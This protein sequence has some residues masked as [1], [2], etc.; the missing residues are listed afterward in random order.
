MR[1]VRHAGQF[2]RDLRLAKR[3]GRDLTKLSEI[4]DLL[5]GGGALPEAKRD[6]KLQG[7]QWHG[8][9]ECH[10]E[11]DWLLIYRIGQDEVQLVRTGTHS[12]LF[13]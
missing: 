4:L 5:I 7:G 11:P 2:T 8:C 3:R 12:D 9:R 6:H 13:G 10:I 1:A